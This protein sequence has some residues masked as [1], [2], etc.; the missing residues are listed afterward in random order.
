VRTL[1]PKEVHLYLQTVSKRDLN[2]SQEDQMDIR[3]RKEVITARGENQVCYIRNIYK[4]ILIL[5]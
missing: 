1:E 3:I 5:V 2:A 4:M